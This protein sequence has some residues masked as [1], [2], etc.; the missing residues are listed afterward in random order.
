VDHAIAVGDDRYEVLTGQ[1]PDRLDVREA[2]MAELRL[3]A[4]VR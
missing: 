4:L 1:R 2:D 3:E